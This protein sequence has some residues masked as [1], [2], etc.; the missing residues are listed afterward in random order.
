MGE[1]RAK[2]G[3]VCEGGEDGQGG[4]D[5]ERKEG[6]EEDGSRS[7]QAEGKMVGNV[8]GRRTTDD[9]KQRYRY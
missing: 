7:R 2:I 1:G 3:R 8:E 9:Q 4:S 5:L 6:E